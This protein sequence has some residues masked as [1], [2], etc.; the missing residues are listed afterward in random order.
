MNPTRRRRQVHYVHA[1]QPNKKLR[2][3]LRLRS[4]AAAFR[5]CDRFFRKHVLVGRRGR[6]LRR[7]GER[8]AMSFLAEMP[9]LREWV[10]AREVVVDEAAPGADHSAVQIVKV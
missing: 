4:D 2:K 6:L 8:Q 10:Q 3:L 7:Q 1:G 5:A 9:I